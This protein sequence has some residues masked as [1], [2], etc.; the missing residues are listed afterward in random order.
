MTMSLT[1]RVMIAIGNNNL[2]HEKYW[3]SVYASMDL[4]IGTKTISF[5]K[6]FDHN[7]IYK[8]KYQKQKEVKTK[9][10][11]SNNNKIKEQT[12]QQEKD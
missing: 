7:R 5:L 6:S 9:R 3:T 10:S 12:E 4:K 2:G 11:Q 8:G 1:N